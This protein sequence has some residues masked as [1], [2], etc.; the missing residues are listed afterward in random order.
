VAAV[1]GA[2][3]GTLLDAEP[4]D[5]ESLAREYATA[6]GL[7]EQFLAALRQAGTFENVNRALDDVAR[8]L[9]ADHGG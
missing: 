9:A 7:N 2:L 5:F 1:L 3:S 4:T 6:G 8:R